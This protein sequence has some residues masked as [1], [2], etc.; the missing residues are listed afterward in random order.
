MT[1]SESCHHNLNY[2]C[3]I[4]HVFS[5]CFTVSTGDDPTCQHNQKLSFSSASTKKA[6]SDYEFFLGMYQ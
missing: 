4:F 1:S 6:D 2:I 3:Y 5:I